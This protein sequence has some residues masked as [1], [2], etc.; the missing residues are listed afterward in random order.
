VQEFEMAGDLMLLRASEGEEH[1]YSPIQNTWE[2]I[3]RPP[4]MMPGR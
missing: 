4:S 3:H 2:K 1:E